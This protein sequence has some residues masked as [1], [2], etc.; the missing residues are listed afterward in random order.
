LEYEHEAR[1][2]NTNYKTQAEAIAEAKS[3]GHQPVVARVRNTSK[4]NPDHWR[5]A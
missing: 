2:T 1:V 4:G 5:A 3:L